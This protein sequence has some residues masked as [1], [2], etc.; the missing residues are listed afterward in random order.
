MLIL[1][2]PP[3][4]KVL[5][6]T[7]PP[8]LLMITREKTVLCLS[9]VSQILPTEP[10]EARIHVGDIIVKIYMSQNAGFYA[11]LAGSS[12]HRGETMNLRWRVSS[13]LSYVRMQAYIRICADMQTLES[14]LED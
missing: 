14:Y 10:E 13:R 6:Y 7:R 8:A 1:L 3:S 5:L 11:A 2:R 9:W 4:W 12:V